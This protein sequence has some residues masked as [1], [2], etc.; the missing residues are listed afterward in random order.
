MQR[1]HVRL[2]SD[3]AGWCAE[4]ARQLAPVA[5]IVVTASVRLGALT[6]SPDAPGTVVLVEAGMALDRALEALTRQ[7]RSS[8][9]AAYVLAVPADPASA[10]PRASLAGVRV[11]LRSDCELPELAEGIYRA[12]DCVAGLA[13]SAGH[14]ASRDGVIVVFGTKG[15]SGKTT[16][17]VNLAAAF[18]RR[19]LRTALLDLHLDWGTASVHLRGAPP[20]PFTELLPEVG[21]LDA[22]LLQSF[23]ARHPSGVSVLPAPPK[24][25]MAEFVTAAHVAAIVAA[26]R[27]G[28]DAVVADTPP[29]FPATLFPA[30]EAADHLLA[31]TT[32]EVA[33]L[34]N[35]RAGLAVL[36]LLQLPRAKVHLV[37]NRATATLGV[38]RADVEA[39]LG[40]PVWAALPSD[41]AT[42]GR[43]GNEGLLVVT[44]AQGSRYGR[45]VTALARQLRPE[46][47]ERPGAPA[48]LRPRRALRAGTA[49]P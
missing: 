27:D 7:T 41:A 9:A 21:R 16:L 10:Y 14:P 15:G 18:A 48:V 24:P 22:D 26:A 31:V 11:V 33:A 5:D 45:A 30:L 44:A 43:A 29:G 20:R 2:V 28:F 46:T 12:A 32:P 19:G 37:L 25:E 49:R 13:A 47:G 36:E 17:A 34:R 8:P 35:M 38:R 23:M 3:D 1:V 40:L 39:T 6:S 42:V 4:R